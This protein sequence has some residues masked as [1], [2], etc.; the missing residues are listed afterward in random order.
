MPTAL[1]SG[2]RSRFV[3]IRWRSTVPLP[4]STISMPQRSCT[5]SAS[6]EKS[7]TVS[8]RSSTCS[9]A[10]FATS[11]KRLLG[12]AR[13]GFTRLTGRFA[14]CARKEN[15]PPG[16]STTSSKTGLPFSSTGR[17]RPTTENAAVRVSSA[18]GRSRYASTLRSFT[19]TARLDVLRT[20]NATATRPLVN[21][22]VW[23]CSYFCCAS[24]F[25]DSV[26]PA[27]ASDEKLCLASNS[28]LTLAL[29]EG[30]K[31]PLNSLSVPTFWLASNEAFAVS[32]AVASVSS[33][34]LS[35]VASVVLVATLP[36][37]TTL[38]SPN[39]SRLIVGSSATRGL[40]PPPVI[41]A[42]SESPSPSV[43]ARIGEV[44][45][46]ITS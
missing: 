41:S 20:L 23:F 18:G 10:K 3:A 30:G 14:F 32:E 5:R 39:T 25:D 29:P 27:E 13:S 8:P 15:S 34:R 46:C 24:C 11:K 21:S 43:S 16:A 31:P 26:K 38:G 19:F 45:A 9:I 33:V 36:T 4:K 42:K 22:A 40:S 17:S 44:F 2:F 28:V 1:P 12:L 6:A 35:S 7:A 37:S